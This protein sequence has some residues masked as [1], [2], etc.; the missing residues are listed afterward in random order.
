MLWP[1]LEYKPLFRGLGWVLLE[2]VGP[3]DTMLHGDQFLSFF[4]HH[5][6]QQQVT[7]PGPLLP[8]PLTTVDHGDT[9]QQQQ[10]PR[11][12]ARSSSTAVGDRYQAWSSA[13][14]EGCWVCCYSARMCQEGSS[15]CSFWEEL[16]CS[17]EVFL[18][19]NHPPKRLGSKLANDIKEAIPC[20]S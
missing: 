17:L 16:L 15:E 12:P 3:E 8:T 9:T 11:T 14:H 10:Q 18:C 4:L 13:E 5:L 19:Q 2:G 1:S 6:R 20:T 7:Y